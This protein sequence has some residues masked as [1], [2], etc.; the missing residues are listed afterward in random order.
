M[1]T[2]LRDFRHEQ[3]CK[4]IQLVHYSLIYFI[5]LHLRP[6]GGGAP[7][8]TITNL[9]TLQISHLSPFSDVIH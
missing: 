5:P 2:K 8:P 9:M 7:Q 3:S 1:G 4:D 6:G